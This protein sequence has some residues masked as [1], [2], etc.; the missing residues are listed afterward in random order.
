M[1]SNLHFLFFGA[2]GAASLVKV[3]YCQDSC[4]KITTGDLGMSNMLDNTGLVA[5]VLI[6]GENQTVNVSIL[7]M[8]IVCEA[9]YNMMQDRYKYTSVVVLFDRTRQGSDGNVSV[10]TDLEQFDF[11]C[12]NGTWSSNNSITTRTTDPI[13]NLSSTL[14]PDCQQCINPNNTEAESLHDRLNNVTHC[15]HEAEGK[16][17]QIHNIIT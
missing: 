6:Q 10:T 17:L 11:E 2:L 3:I 12:V 13:A 5:T 16:Y 15:V 14:D 9:R 7:D 1:V 4:E 8:N